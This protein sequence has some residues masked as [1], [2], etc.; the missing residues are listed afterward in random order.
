V[1]ETYITIQGF[2]IRDFTTNSAAYVPTG[3]WITDSGTRVH[4]LNNVVHNITTKPEENGN[5][6]GVSVY[7]TSKTPITQLLISG[8]EVYELKTGSSE[9]VNVDGNVTHFAITN[10]LVHDDD[11][12]GIDAIGYE[13]VGPVGY[14]EAMYGE[15]S[16]NTIYNISGITN[17][18]EGN[19]YDADGLYCDGCAYVTFERNVIFHYPTR[20]NFVLSQDH[21]FPF[22]EAQSQ[23][24]SS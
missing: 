22:T 19:Q 24:Q 15:I 6:F 2:E 10:N 17:P 20:W 18:G 5:A 1:N 8:N 21:R 13:G 7:G 16:E 9:S 14:D 4:I 11:N 3:V 23:R 12:I